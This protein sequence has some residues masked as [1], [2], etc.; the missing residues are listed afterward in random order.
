MTAIGN[1]FT[2]RKHENDIIM[3]VIAIY[4]CWSSGVNASLTLGDDLPLPFSPA[5]LP[6]LPLPSPPHLT[7]SHPSPPLPLEVGPLNAAR[8][9]GGALLAPP[10]GA[11][12]QPKSNF[13]HFSLKI[14]HLVATILMIFLRVLPKKFSVAHYSGAQELGGPLNRLDPRFLLRWFFRYCVER[15][16]GVNSGTSCR[17]R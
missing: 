13:V 6:S 10:A 16:N 17:C 14:R 11:E 4:I 3:I 2:Q 5:P 8:G 15:R 7:L 9:S 12:P 1:L